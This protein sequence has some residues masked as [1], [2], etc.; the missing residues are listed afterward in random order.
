VAFSKYQSSRNGKKEKSPMK[1]RDIMTSEGLATATLDT[2]LEDI[3]NMMKDENV[4]AIPVLD[5]ED[6]LAGIITDRDIVV[7]GIAEGQDPTSCTAEEILSEQLHTIE[8]DAELEEAAELMARHKIR[9][10]PVVEDGVIIGMISL[11]DISVKAEDE[12]QAG[13][14]LGDISEG[15]KQESGRSAPGSGN[16]GSRGQQQTSGRERENE[17]QQSSR[18]GAT[19]ERQSRGSAQR[20]G[21]VDSQ[22]NAIGRSSGEQVAAEETEYQRQS[23]PRAGAHQGG[24]RAEN[25]VAGRVRN[26]SRSQQ[27]V[28][29]DLV[30]TEGEEEPEYQNAGAGA[31]R[32]R[33]NQQQPSAR[34]RQSSSAR[35]RDAGQVRGTDRAQSGRQGIS[36]RG[37]GEE[38][39]GQQKVTSTREE[40]GSA[41][42][43]RGGKKRAS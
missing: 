34:G 21:S 36:N 16:G 12:G 41:G 40:A 13:E 2:T 43:N 10:L 42:R 8:P 3:A 25:A 11:G 5:D 23:A 20:S 9:R 6:N 37:V 32:Q 17:R 30:N 4:G 31:G 15:V 38:R 14:A 39:K 19:S 28:A 1:V 22:F 27:S 29:N 7:R 18:R 35:G 24:T 33:G 26:Q